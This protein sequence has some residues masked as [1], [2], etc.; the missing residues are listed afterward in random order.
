M[1]PVGPFRAPSGLV[2]RAIGARLNSFAVRIP[3]PWTTAALLA[4]TL[5]IAQVICSTKSL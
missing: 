1:A 4:P 3:L 5:D 2:E